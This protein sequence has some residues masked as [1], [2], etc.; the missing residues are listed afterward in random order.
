MMTKSK[1][2]EE[3]L[4]ALGEAVFPIKFHKN[5]EGL[6]KTMLVRDALN[7]IKDEVMRSDM[8]IAAEL[9][10]LSK[11]PSEQEWVND[12]GEIFTW[13][14]KGFVATGGYRW[15]THNEAFLIYCRC[16]YPKRNEN[17]PLS[18]CNGCGKQIL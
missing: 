16:A 9:Q 8:E 17:T 6:R 5:S 2:T 10:N 12:S 4:K 15:K 3:H 13:S 14:D 18:T 11:C 1:L 7:I